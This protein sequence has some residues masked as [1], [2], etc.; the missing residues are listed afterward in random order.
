[1]REAI[2]A[3]KSKKGAE[4]PHVFKGPVEHAIA[5]I[6]ESIENVVSK[7]NLRWYAIK[8]FER[9][10][11][12][13]EELK[14]GADLK[15]HLEEHIKDCEKELEDDS[16]SIVT[17]QRYTY[18]TG[19]IGGAVTKGHK[20]KK[21]SKSDRIDR[22]VTNRILALP[23]FAVV[24]FAVYY[25]A[26]TTIGTYVTD[27]T[28]DT[29]VG[30]ILQPG[31]ENLLKGAGASEWVISL[32]KDGIIGELRAPLSFAPQMAIVFLFLTILEDCGYMARVAFIMDRIFRRFGL[33]GK[34]FIPF[35]I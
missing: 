9:D 26:V 10:E 2:E 16:E 3:A 4:S 28:N 20:G 30:G 18:I 13:L 11:K 29:F 1:M 7:E 25:V 17:N 27:W 8:I 5:H 23:I 33:S 15:N 35:L 19:I 34:S 12:I 31:A 22:I 32:V 21:L 6:E 14:L 24:M